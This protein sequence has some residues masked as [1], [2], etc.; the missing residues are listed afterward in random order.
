M[1]IPIFTE[2]AECI[3]CHQTFTRRFGGGN[4]FPKPLRCNVCCDLWQPKPDRLN[5]ASQTTKNGDCESELTRKTGIPT[6]YTEET[7]DSYQPRTA[8]ERNA[9]AD[10]RQWADDI[11]ENVR[12]GSA[13]VLSGPLGTGKTHLACCI[14]KK[15]HEAGVKVRFYKLSQIIRE[16]AEAAQR[17]EGEEEKTIQRFAKLPLLVIDEVR[18]NVVTE[19]MKS[20]VI[21]IFDARWD[22]G[23]PIV[24]TTNLLVS[25]DLKRDELQLVVS[26][27]SVSRM[28][29]RGMTLCICDGPDY[30]KTKSN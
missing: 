2:E 16:L 5:L 18:P 27:L 13:L 1:S 20:R 28:Y 4:P 7:F 9:L 24:L 21:D 3:D 29:G 22:R 25:K 17:G 23:L 15:A 8:S 11:L 30:R 12:E 26:D 6:K 14:A 10:C 19:T